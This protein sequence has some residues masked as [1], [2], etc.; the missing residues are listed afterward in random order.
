MTQNEKP[1]IEQ[2]AGCFNLLENAVL[3]LDQVRVGLA[4]VWE[5]TFEDS[6]ADQQR[7]I[8]GTIC[9]MHPDSSRDFDLRVSTGSEISIAGKQ[10]RVIDVS[11]GK[12]Y[13]SLTLEQME[14]TD[15]GR[16]ELPCSPSNVHAAPSL[17]GI[18]YLLPIP[19][20]CLPYVANSA[21]ARATLAVV[22]LLLWF[23]LVR[24]NW[25][26]VQGFYTTI[27]LLLHCLFWMFIAICRGLFG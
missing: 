12:P 21:T 6:N 4:N 26:G 11:E 18:D 7:G 10:F 15:S 14:R 13:G 24:P 19:F 3:D 1:I 8:R 20:L 23:I 16:N 27:L 2:N 9:V 5:E 25:R 22:C 17:N